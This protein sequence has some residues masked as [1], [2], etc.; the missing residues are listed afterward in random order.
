[1][2]AQLSDAKAQGDDS[3]PEGHR[4]ASSDCLTSSTGYTPGKLASKFRSKVV[5]IA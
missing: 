5:Y 2:V 4:Q 1:M 3:S